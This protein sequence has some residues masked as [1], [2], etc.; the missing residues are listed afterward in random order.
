MMMMSINLKKQS[1]IQRKNE[2]NKV[3]IYPFK[4]C[5]YSLTVVHLKRVKINNSGKCKYTF[6][7]L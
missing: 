2:N 3:L 5:M 4:D 6:A 7:L 1:R